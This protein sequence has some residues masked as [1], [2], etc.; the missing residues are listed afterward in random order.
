MIRRLKKDVLK[1]LPP[2]IRNTVKI[3]IDPKVKKE[4]DKLKAEMQSQG[5]DVNKQIDK[6]VG[7]TPGYDTVG[8]QNY[9]Q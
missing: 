7:T 5:I 6:L 3:E 8:F 4:I 9:F 1:E 2:K